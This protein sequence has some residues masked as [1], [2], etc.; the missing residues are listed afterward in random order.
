MAQFM[1]AVLFAA[2]SGRPGRVFHGKMTKPQAVIQPVGQKAVYLNLF[3]RVVHKAV[4]VIVYRC[5]LALPIAADDF[6][7]VRIVVDP[8][9]HLRVVQPPATVMNLLKQQGF[10]KL[11]GLQNFNAHPAQIL[12]LPVQ[13][14]FANRLAVGLQLA[15]LAQALVVTITQRAQL[16]QVRHI[17]LGPFYPLRH[18]R[19]SRRSLSRFSCS[20]WIAMMAA[21]LLMRPS[22]IMAK[23]SSA[24]TTWLR[25]SSCSCSTPKTPPALA[26]LTWPQ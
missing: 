7:H 1:A 2:L 13:L 23:H 5:N 12:V 26:V 18:A 15:Q 17:P 20:H 4:R 9:R 16:A 10:R 24:L 25:M 8:H 21:A 11:G 19:H 6:R 3:I 22:A 14:K